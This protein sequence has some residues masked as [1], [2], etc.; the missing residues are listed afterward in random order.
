MLLTIVSVI[1]VLVAVAMIVLI[2][3]QRGSGA[4]AGSG[5]GAGASATVF[6][7]RGSAN[8]LS[9]STKWLAVVFFAMTLGIAY[10]HKDERAGVPAPVTQDDDLGAMGSADAIPGAPAD[11]VPSAPADAAPVDAAAPAAGDNESVPAIEQGDVPEAAPANSAEDE[12]AA[13]NGSENG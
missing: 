4:A 12:N 11:G 1:Y 6:G 5:F 3:M 8:F 10:Y 2:L 7:A 13:G 9:T